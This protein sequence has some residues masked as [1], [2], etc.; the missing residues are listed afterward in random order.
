M[1]QIKD[2]RKYFVDELNKL[3]EWF[4][5]FLL[6]VITLIIFCQVSNTILS[7]LVWKL[8][9][10]TQITNFNYKKKLIK[11]HCGFKLSF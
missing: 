2:K 5:W 7:Q 8:I 10:K 4:K 3:E 6:T 1:K 11:P 9:F